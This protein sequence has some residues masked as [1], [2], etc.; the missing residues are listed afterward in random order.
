M[1]DWD[2]LLETVAQS[3]QDVERPARVTAAVSGGADSVALLQALH[4]LSSKEVFFLSA[5]HVDHGL[6][7]TSGRDADFVARMCADLGVPCKIC[8]VQ[9]KGKSED[10]ARQARYAALEEA[11][12]EFDTDVLALAHH[13]R[14]QAET[15][16]LH[17][18]RGSGAGGLAA[19]AE[20]GR[21][22]KMLLWRP[23]LNVSPEIIRGALTEKG[24]PWVEDETNARDDYLRNY[25]RHQVLPV[26]G[27]RFP[28]AEEA[29][30]RT[31]RILADEDDYFRTE[32]KRFLASP[33]NACLRS[34][35][36]WIR[37]A[38][39]QSLHPA[40]R[41]YVLRLA[42]PVKL[43]AETTEALIRLSS[44]QKMNLPGN[45]RAECSQQY[46]HLLSEN[47][48]APIP[49]R[50]TA[51]PWQGK[52]GDGKRVQAMR[53]GVYEHCE[54]RFLRPGDR[55]LPL[56]S[57]GTKSMQDYFVDKKVP[58]PFRKYIP[59]LCID[60]QVIWAVGVG[61]GEEARVSPGDEAV[62]LHYEGFIPGRFSLNEQSQKE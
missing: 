19:M 13:R 58:R 4:E 15:V 11:C 34:P 47:E 35:C 24:I 61:V 14:D 10:A 1:S 28:Q 27:A 42:C 53:R 36:R 45:G 20:T 57:K 49:G 59:L 37:L 9:V 12:L 2:F 30:G 25:V 48:E 40:L 54:L 29:M 33:D 41:R 50:L 22:D 55:I 5:A 18:F 44:G 16:L 26:I 23:L 3:W 46:L 60:S 38:A 51:E 21:R 17:L 39:L 7:E 32:A 8:R 31:A 52:T 6:R 56:G 43:D 62:L